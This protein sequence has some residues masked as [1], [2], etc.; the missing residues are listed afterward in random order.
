M[1]KEKAE[2]NNNGKE[3]QKINH[4]ESE[5]KKAEQNHFD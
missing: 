3:T 4:G 1:K 5:C 2:Y